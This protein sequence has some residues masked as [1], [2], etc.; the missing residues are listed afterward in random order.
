MLCHRKHSHCRD[1]SLMSG[2]PRAAFAQIANYQIAKQCQD[3]MCPLV[4]RHISTTHKNYINLKT[5]F[6]VSNYKKIIC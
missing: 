3:D 2:P 5:S 1:G 6:D 4:N